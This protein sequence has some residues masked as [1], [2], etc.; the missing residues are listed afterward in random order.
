MNKNFLKFSKMNKL[1]KLITLFMLFNS[2]LFA[3]NRENFKKVE[4][5]GRSILLPK[6]IETSR[7]RALEDAL[8]IAASKVEQML[9][10]F[11]LLIQI[12]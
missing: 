6:N 9:M 8:Y 4:A 12:L 5:T 7:K 1:L 3:K 10:V 2:E 11:P